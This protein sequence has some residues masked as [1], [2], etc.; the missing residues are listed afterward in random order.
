MVVRQDNIAGLRL[1]FPH[2]KPAIYDPERLVP[3]MSFHVWSALFTQ[4]IHHAYSLPAMTNLH[5]SL[6]II[7]HEWSLEL[8]IR[9]LLWALVR[10]LEAVILLS[11][12]LVFLFQRRKRGTKKRQ[13]QQ[14]QTV[15]PTTWYHPL[16]AQ[17]FLASSFSFQCYGLSLPFHEEATRK[18][19]KV[20]SN[21][22]LSCTVSLVASK[23][24]NLL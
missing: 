19:E 2:K 12:L 1:N 24:L 11:Y 22:W 3:A 9:E 17:R 16:Q 10:E 14:L 5:S 18:R 20:A 7:L 13:R 15:I 23:R 21:P 4:G 8:V 6:T